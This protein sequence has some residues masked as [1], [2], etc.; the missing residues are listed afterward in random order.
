VY[1]VIPISDEQIKIDLA[2]DCRLAEA[3]NN[4]HR[5]AELMH[6][7]NFFRA[8]HYATRARRKATL[9][10][11]EG[12]NT[13]LYFGRISGKAEMQMHLGGEILEVYKQ[14]Y[15][16]IRE[17]EPEACDIMDHGDNSRFRRRSI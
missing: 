13:P 17:N 9:V 11:R 4:I 6:A 15:D 10:V 5:A 12:E 8:A 1:T 2:V 7:E 16:A 14:I 3:R